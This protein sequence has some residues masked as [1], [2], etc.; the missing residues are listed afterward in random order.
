MVSLA[1]NIALMG[2]ILVSGVLAQLARAL[3]NLDA[4]Q[5]RAEAEQIACGNSVSIS[6]LTEPA[7]HEALAKGFGWVTLYGG[8]SVWILAGIRFL[9]FNV[10]P[11]AQPGS[12]PAS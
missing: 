1:I 9:V 6:G 7:M 11:V 2:F 10:R 4:T 12:E 5:L 3:P 8:I